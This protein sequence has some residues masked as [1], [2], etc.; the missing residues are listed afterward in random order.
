MEG[1]FAWLRNNFDLVHGSQQGK[2]VLF[3]RILRRQ[4]VPKPLLYVGILGIDR[5][6]CTE[7]GGGFRIA[8]LL[9]YLEGKLR[10]SV[11][12]L[13]FEHLAP[14]EILEIVRDEGHTGTA[15]FTG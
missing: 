12:H 3:V 9:R 15:N 1:G 4:Y 13:E 5:Q 8:A 6:S 2:D 11:G 10:M 7:L 14:G